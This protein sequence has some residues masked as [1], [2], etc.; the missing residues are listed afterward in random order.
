M[1]VLDSFDEPL[2]FPVF[3]PAE[4]SPEGLCDVRTLPL[5][6]LTDGRFEH[7]DRFDGGALERKSSQIKSSQ[8]KT[9]ISY[10]YILYNYI[11][12]CLNDLL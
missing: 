12:T 11:K 6:A 9:D 10:I 1:H 2:R 3:L 4:Y 8:N 7:S 5:W